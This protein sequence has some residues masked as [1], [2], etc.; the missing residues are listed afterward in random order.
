MNL[1]IQE[2]ADL[3]ELV[4][5][6]AILV[7]LVYLALQTRQGKQIARSDAARNVMSEFQAVWS[8]LE[9]SDEFTRL[10]RKAVNGWS[11]LSRNEQ[12]RAH[13][14]FC[15]LIVHY[16][17]TVRQIYLADMEHVMA[18]IENNILGLIQSPGGREWYETCQYLF[19]ADARQRLN[20]RLARQTALPPAWTT[21]MSWWRLDDHEA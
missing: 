21:G 5:S 7:S 15:N 2:L 14:F 20:D 9:T 3:G 6:I 1:S 16:Q 10:V 19:E 4:G 12:M 11:A 8:S 13:A 17:G 18:A